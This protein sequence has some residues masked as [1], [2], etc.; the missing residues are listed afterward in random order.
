M[1]SPRGRPKKVTGQRQGC[2]MATRLWV[3]LPVAVDAF[4]CSGWWKSSADR[5]GALTRDLAS[6][7]QH[8]GVSE[9]SC[10]VIGI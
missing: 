6:Y 2:S 4:G 1:Q 10:C 5:S 9:Q 7:D 3:M 8:R